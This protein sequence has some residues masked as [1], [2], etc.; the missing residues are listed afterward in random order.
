VLTRDIHVAHF[1]NS[2]SAT[3]LTCLPTEGEHKGT[4]DIFRV[5]LASVNLLHV[6]F[7]NTA[8]S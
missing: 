3:E 8:P 2:T 6:L 5:G 7:S 4:T 1:K